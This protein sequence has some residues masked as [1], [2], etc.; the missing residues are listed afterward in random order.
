ML[1][2]VEIAG[3][4]HQNEELGPKVVVPEILKDTTAKKI[5]LV[6]FFG[7]FFVCMA[8]FLLPGTELIW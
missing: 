4:Q 5:Y 7:V 1:K 8:A 6:R 2:F 3:T